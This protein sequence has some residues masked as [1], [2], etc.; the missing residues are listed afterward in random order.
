MCTFLSTPQQWCCH[1]PDATFSL[2]V[3][4]S[5]P[6]RASVLLS[7]PLDQSEIPEEDH[8]EGHERFD[9]SLLQSAS[10]NGHAMREAME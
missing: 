10:L 6:F 4:H 1:W 3:D 7:V 2:R 8:K 9:V 5:I